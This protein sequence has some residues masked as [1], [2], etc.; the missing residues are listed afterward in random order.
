MTP[1]QLYGCYDNKNNEW[2]DGVFTSIMR[3]CSK[4]N[5]PKNHW[6]TFDGPV[7]ALYVE[8]MNTVMDDNKRLCLP[9]NELIPLNP[10][11]KIV[12]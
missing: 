5:S 6:I 2:K 4:D 12:F 7:D 3:E 9:T 11:M 1:D 8:C 10:N